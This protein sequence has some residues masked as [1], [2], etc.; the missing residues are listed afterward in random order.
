MQGIFVAPGKWSS[1]LNTYD[2][3][4]DFECGQS[5]T[6]AGALIGAKSTFSD[7][8]NDRVWYYQCGKLLFNTMQPRN[9]DKSDI[10]KILVVGVY[11]GYLH[12]T[13]VT[14]TDQGAAFR[15]ITRLGVSWR[16]CTRHWSPLP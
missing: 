11:K 16:S 6:C 1:A 2:G 8:A 7:G 5:G 15:S 10:Y 14:N 13:P 3:P 9:D 4:V 12:H